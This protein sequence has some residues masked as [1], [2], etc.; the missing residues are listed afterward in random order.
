MKLST[1]VKELDLE[2]I[3]GYEKSNEGKDATGVYICD[4]LS[5]VMGKA[6][7]HNIWI[8]IQTHTNIIA[9]ATLLDL[10][11]IIVAEDLD[12]DED[13]IAKSNAVNVPLFKSKLSSYELAYKLREIGV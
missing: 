11:A 4:L 5:L 9:V 8:T 2:I 12:I 7:E 1:I 3:A 10:S 6:K 13:T